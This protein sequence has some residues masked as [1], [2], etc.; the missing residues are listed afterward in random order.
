MATN[1]LEQINT[2]LIPSPRNYRVLLP[3][4]EHSDLPLLLL[5]HGGNGSSDF[6]TQM[7]PGIE[8]AW[9]DGSLPAMAVATLDADRSFYLDFA[10]GSQ[11]WETFMVKEW[12]P[13]LRQ[14]LPVGSTQEK[15]LI[16]GISMG[17][18]GTTRIGMRYPEMFH[19]M[20]AMEPAIMPGMTLAEVPE[21]N[22]A[23]HKEVLNERYGDPADE[24]WN[25]NNPA[26]LALDNTAQI[27]SSGIKIYLEVGTD[28]FFFL[29]EGTEFFHQTLLQAGIKHEYRVMLGG[30]HVGNSVEPRFLDML[31]FLGR[32]LAEPQ[33]DPQLDQVMEFLG[34]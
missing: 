19:A 3:R 27:K 5:L 28:D 22:I 11:A 29:N 26:Q 34:V 24:H 7:Q 21:K 30:N 32:S 4:G 1:T 17:G 8:Q 13:H 18:H 10:D 15:T 9:A 16:A 23:L 14:T 31:G 2:T 25:A 12:L 6:L 33:P 20:A